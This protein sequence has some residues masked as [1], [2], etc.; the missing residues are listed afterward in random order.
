MRKRNLKLKEHGISCKRYNELLWYCRQYPDWV[1]E[2]NN[3]TVIKSQNVTGMP[4]G[5]GGTSNQTEELAIRRQELFK[6][7]E[8]I[9][10][11]AIEADGDLYQYII[12]NVCYN[13]SANYLVTHDMPCTAS[14][15]YDKRRYFF[16]LL[17]KNKKY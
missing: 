8:L 3:M 1:S 13:K 9:E 15:L 12:K 6:K 16:Y 4:N 2:L 11:T 14:T 17:D 10:Q 7:C 5:S